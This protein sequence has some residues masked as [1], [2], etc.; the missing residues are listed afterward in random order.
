[1]I[2]PIMQQHMSMA[3]Y[4]ERMAHLRQDWGHGPLINLRP[5]MRW[6][7]RHL[8]ALGRAMQGE[9]A[10]STPPTRRIAH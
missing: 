4:E 2:D 6:I 7:G 10:L 3:I 1:M 5:V 9:E 8:V